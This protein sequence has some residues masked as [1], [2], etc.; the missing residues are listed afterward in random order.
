MAIVELSIVPIGTA[1]TSVSK[2]VA[3]V[4]D[5][6]AEEKNIKYALTPMSTILEGEL[7][8][9]LAVVRKLHELPFDRGALRVYSTLKIDDRRDKPSTM[10]A[11]L[12]AVNKKIKK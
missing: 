5:A 8:H 4:H 6:L 1:S 9:I 11:K 3:A 7:D 2:Y 10:A 12:D